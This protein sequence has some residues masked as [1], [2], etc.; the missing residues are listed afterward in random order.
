M[1]NIGG[2]FVHLYVIGFSHGVVKV[3]W[4]SKPHDRITYHTKNCN[5]YDRRVV[6]YWI[7][8]ECDDAR[9]LERGL[10]S[11]CRMYE[12]DHG[13]RSKEYFKLPFDAV[14]TRA[15]TLTLNRSTPLGAT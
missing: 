8:D 4:T 12:V 11:W 5:N 10:I 14:V 13:C 3:G 9:E 7:S 15:Q 6:A 2:F 1:S